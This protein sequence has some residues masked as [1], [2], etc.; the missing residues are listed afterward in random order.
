MRKWFIHYIHAL[1]LSLTWTGCSFW[2]NVKYFSYTFLRGAFQTAL[3]TEMQKHIKSSFKKTKTLIYRR[4]KNSFYV[5]AKPNLCDTRVVTKY[6]GRYLGRP[7][8]PWNG[9]IPMTAASSLSITT[10]IKTIFYP[11]NCPCHG[12]YSLLVQQIPD[13]NFKMIRYYGLYAR[14]GKQEVKLSWTTKL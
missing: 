14:H 5:Y 4:D 2:R 8:S 12:L 10:A 1:L 13:W 11:R 6:I 7:P 9:L 3:L